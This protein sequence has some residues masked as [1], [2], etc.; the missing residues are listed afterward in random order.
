MPLFYLVVFAASCCVWASDGNLLVTL[1]AALLILNA[2]LNWR[3]EV[4]T[5]RRPGKVSKVRRVD[6]VARVGRE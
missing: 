2:A 5:S 6:R 3:N 4:R 1:Q